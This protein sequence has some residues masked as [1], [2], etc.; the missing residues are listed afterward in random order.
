MRKA[1][2]GVAAAGAVVGLGVVGRRMGHRMREHCAQMA[3]QTA[4]QFEDHGAAV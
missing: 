1:I 4:R 3:R 2:I